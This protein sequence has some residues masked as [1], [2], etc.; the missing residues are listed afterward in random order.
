MRVFCQC[1]WAL[2]THV[3]H[4]FR[5]CPCLIL[6]RLNEVVS[7]DLIVVHTML[8]K[9]IH[10]VIRFS[11]IHTGPP[12]ATGAAAGSAGGDSPRF[13]NFARF[14]GVVGAPPTGGRV[15]LA[16]VPGANPSGGRNSFVPPLSR[17]RMRDKDLACRS[18][19]GTPFP[20]EG[21]RK[22]HFLLG[23]TLFWHKK[24]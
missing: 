6:S 20:F 17:S 13:L 19:R 24:E 1:L 15:H 2:N 7:G 10:Q 4:S 5:L 3:E 18:G 16:G 12:G 9:G 8:A 11:P 22:C 23:P 21:G 14:L